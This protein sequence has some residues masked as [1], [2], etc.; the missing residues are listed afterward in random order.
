MDNL[1][2][3]SV[4][5]V[6]VSGY[7][8]FLRRGNV[9]RRKKEKTLGYNGPVHLSTNNTRSRWVDKWSFVTAHCH[10][11]KQSLENVSMNE[12]STEMV[13]ARD[14]KRVRGEEEIEE[15]PLCCSPH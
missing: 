8:L 5:F 9:K 6:F 4:P 3:I 12:E 14:R 7:F 10:G 2:T 13:T 1:S 11:T 15:I